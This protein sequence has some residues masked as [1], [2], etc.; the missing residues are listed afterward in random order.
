M[1][2]HS[3][4][5]IYR[6][7]VE[8][9]EVNRKSTST[10]DEIDTS[11]DLIN[12]NRDPLLHKP[13]TSPEKQIDMHPTVISEHRRNE[14]E[15]RGRYDRDRD[16]DS[17]DTMNRGDDEG[18]RDA[19]RQADQIIRVAEAA[20]A[21]ILPLPGKEQDL[22]VF[23]LKNQYVHSAMV[24][25]GYQLVAAH[26][27]D[28]IKTKITKGEFVDFAQ[29]L[30]RDRISKTEDYR[31]E[32]V[33]KDGRTYFVP[34][35]EKENSGVISNFSRWE[36][37]FRVFSD[38]YTRHFPNRAAELIQYNHLIHTASL[39]FSCKNVYNYDR[40]F[41]IHMARNPSRSWAI[42]LQQAWSIRLKDKH[43]A[44]SSYDRTDGRK[45][46]DLCYR[47]NRGRCSCGNKCK[48]EHRCGMCN[49]FGHG[50]FNCR[51][52]GNGRRTQSGDRRDDDYDRGDKSRNPRPST[53]K[54]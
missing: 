28:N 50:T 17:R 49:K 29:L 16:R 36:Q 43:G 11:D 20:K 14:G 34:A 42:I 30:P 15:S 46:R 26:V 5:T 38:I 7:A 53:S 32:L 47:F 9:M 12:L 48:F 22:D 52:M 6:N 1:G 8:P 40:D 10:E 25:K 33:N 2:S 18:I 39:S 27:N 35:S 44:A 21:K 51:K 54:N 3:E 23:D 19:E 24:D 37:A 41:R 31:M 4:T 13:V 45:K